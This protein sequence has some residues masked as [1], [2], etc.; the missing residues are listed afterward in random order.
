MLYK[1]KLFGDYGPETQ[2]LKTTGE[3]VEN[4]PFYQFPGTVCSK[5]SV[6]WGKGQFTGKALICSFKFRGII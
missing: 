2:F 4:H 6:P 3:M 5:D 1:Q